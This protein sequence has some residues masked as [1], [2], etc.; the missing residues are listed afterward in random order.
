MVKRPS[1]WDDDRHVT[2]SACTV[3]LLALVA[4]VASAPGA[5]AA[6]PALVFER[7]VT[8]AERPTG[9]LAWDMARLDAPGV[10]PAV[11]LLHGGG[12]WRGERADLV[13]ARPLAQAI[14]RAGF[15]VVVPEYRLACGTAD[16]PRR[17]FGID[18]T[19]SAPRCGAT[20]ADQ[21]EDVHEVIRRVRADSTRLGVD[22][23]RIAVMG[24]SAGGHL[25]LLA[26]L[27]GGP[28]VAV[29]TVVN[30]SGPPTTGFIRMQSPRPVYPIRS[31]RASF[32]NAVGCHPTTCPDLW[33]AADPLVQLTSAR[34]RFDVL[35]IVG[36][37]ETQ[38]PRAVMRAFDRRADE[39]G[40]RSDVLVGR[41]ACH[42][43]GCLQE[44]AVGWTQRVLAR[45]LLFLRS[46][47]R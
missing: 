15:V 40:W 32:T 46:S 11:V 23:E 12:W 24:V 1:T 8:Y 21:V 20:M 36:E 47:L 30:V 28:D 42:G 13:V 41:G 16:A 45:T 38:V 25:A 14:A 39:L 2:R 10:R 27:R 4:L 37:T 31:I 3:L 34:R 7:D 29:K 44:P 22:T 9:P 19:S 5:A 43:A 18:F 35:G 26:A 17:A 33:A 6:T